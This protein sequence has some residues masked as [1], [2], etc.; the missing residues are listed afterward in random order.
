MIPGTQPQNRAVSSPINSRPGSYHSAED[1]SDH[2][3][4]SKLQR[5]SF[6][7]GGKSKSR[8]S[9]QETNETH[10]T[11]A[12]VNAGEHKIDYNMTLLTN[13]EKVCTG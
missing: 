8:H 6:L 12:W 11:G 1:G 10:G 2:A 9:S 7:P 3:T 5:K 13:G 4:G